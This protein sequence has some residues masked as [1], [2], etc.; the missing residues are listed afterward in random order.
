[1]SE[2]TSRNRMHNNLTLSV[3]IFHI[4]N[5]RH[6]TGSRPYAETGSQSSFRKYSN[7]LSWRLPH[8]FGQMRSS[9]FT[10][11]PYTWGNW[12]TAISRIVFT[13]RNPPT[14]PSQNRKYFR[15]WRHPNV[16][17]SRVLHSHRILCEYSIRHLMDCTFVTHMFCQASLNEY[18]TNTILGIENIWLAPHYTL[19]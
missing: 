1:M 10:L 4:E 19:E 8:K 18:C 15:K 5:Y 2:C 7:C 17:R 14:H 11:R 6:P 16:G 9:V 12:Q 3:T 13:E